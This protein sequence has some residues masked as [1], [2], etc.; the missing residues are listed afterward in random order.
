MSIPSFRSSPA[1]SA[2]CDAA[3]D[4]AGLFP[5]AKLPMLAAVRNYAAYRLG[6]H[7]AALGRF[8]VP[9]ARLGEFEEAYA[10]LASSEQS[11]WRLSVLAGP[12]LRSDWG[13][14]NAF[15]AN[16][17]EVRITG[18]EFKPATPAD[19]RALPAIPPIIEVWVEVPA[20]GSFETTVEAVAQAGRGAKIRTGGTTPDAFPVA[21]R[22]VDFL[23]LCLRLNL[24]AKATAGLHHPLSGHYPVT[25]EP[26]APTA[27][28][29]GFVN[30]I[31][32]AAHLQNGGSAGSA[33]ELLADT[34]AGHFRHEPGGLS[35][36]E[37]TF[38]TA[39][40]RQARQT[41]VRSFGSCSF[42]EPIEGLQSLG[43][44]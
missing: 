4:Y 12:D 17:P 14:I 43:W 33:A 19:L 40:I 35:W 20:S 30:L 24:C 6:A 10:A 36:K 1:M 21:G 15:H 31:L 25:Y 23:A 18:L 8:V 32:S 29:F 7:S 27:R 37:A 5:P 3:V 13:Q 11:G 22:V 39:Q 16:H 9:V 34:D 26:N 38:S 2:L 44:L 28:M 41:L 42:V